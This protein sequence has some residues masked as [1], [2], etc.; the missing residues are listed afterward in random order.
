MGRLNNFIT[1]DTNQFGPG[2]DLIVSLMAVLLV[3]ILIS[4][5][6]YHRERKRNNSSTELSKQQEQELIALRKRVKEQQ[7]KLESVDSG[8]KFRL[9]SEPFLAG[10]FQTR[11]VDELK[12]PARTNAVVDRIAQ[13]YETLKG[14]F[15]YIFII[16]HSNTVD[17]PNP[18]DTAPQTKAQRNWEYAGRRA[19]V[20]ADLIQERLPDEQKDRIVV[21]TTGEFDLRVPE[22]PDAPEN[23]CVEVIFGKEWKPPSRMH[24][25]ISQ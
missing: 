12:D 17:D 19:E 5:H 6:L 7:K 2:T 13:E 16:G 11:P 22:N 24:A 4:G 23:A 10:D 18:P 20:I 25:A 8:G 15:P 14:E 3:M 9:A 1:E 21:F